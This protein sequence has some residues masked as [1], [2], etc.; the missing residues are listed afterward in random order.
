MGISYT[1]VDNTLGEHWG[2][3]PNLGLGQKPVN[4][5]FNPNNVFNFNFEFQ[6]PW[7]DANQTSL[8]LKLYSNHTLSL[9]SR[10]LDGGV[11]SGVE[12]PKNKYTYS[13]NEK[14]TGLNLTLGRPLNRHL[15]VST[16]PDGTGDD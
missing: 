15:R 12:R 10:S 14:A 11:F 3:D 13:Y 9:S 7:L 4:M 6:E 5:E 8:G 16:F 2:H 1:P